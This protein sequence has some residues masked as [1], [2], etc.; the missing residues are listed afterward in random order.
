MSPETVRLLETFGWVG[1]GVGLLLVAVSVPAL[2][3]ARRQVD[4]LPVSDE[5][6]LDM[7]HS[8]PGVV[9]VHEVSA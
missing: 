1:A 5:H 2:V 6:L 9:V 3:A 8:L 7:A 4:P